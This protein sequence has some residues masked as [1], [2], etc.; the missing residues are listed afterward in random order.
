MHATLEGE[1]AVAPLEHAPVVVEVVHAVAA[2]HLPVEAWYIHGAGA[3]L[4]RACLN[5]CVRGS[6]IHIHYTI[7]SATSHIRTPGY[8]YTYIEREQPAI[9]VRRDA[10]AADGVALDEEARATGAVVHVVN[11]HCARVCVCVHGNVCV[12]YVYIIDPRPV[13][14]RCGDG[15]GRAGPKSFK[16]G[17]GVWNVCCVRRTGAVHLLLVPTAR[18][19]DGLDL[20]I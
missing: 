7:Y 16:T 2:R 10:H 13:W 17:T 9:Y 14:G 12:C 4:V 6:H 5:M 11:L 1:A 18:G 3:L 19:D 20:H 15:T 8:I